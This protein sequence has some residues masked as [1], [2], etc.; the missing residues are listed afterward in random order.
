MRF[1]NILHSDDDSVPK[2]IDNDW[3]GRLTWAELEEYVLG[4]EIT[5]EN[6]IV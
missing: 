5:N 2:P 1:K 6:A 4:V 3:L